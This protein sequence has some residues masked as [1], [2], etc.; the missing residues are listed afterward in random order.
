MLETALSV[1]NKA[2]STYLSLR[3]NNP[4]VLSGDYNIDLRLHR[5][6]SPDQA[7]KAKADGKISVA[8][9]DIALV[10]AICSLLSFLAGTFALAGY[11]VRK[12]FG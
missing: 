1:W 7:C 3:E 10:A 5:Q 2:K 6:D 4:T 8:L 12:L 9:V 11:I